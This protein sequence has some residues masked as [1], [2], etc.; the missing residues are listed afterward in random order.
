MT[1][2]EKGFR[3]EFARLSEKYNE[4]PALLD[5]K[6]GT[7]WTYADLA[8]LT[9]RA[10]AYLAANGA[11][12]GKT[13]VTLLPNS[14]DTLVL[15]LGALRVGANFAPLS[16]QARPREIRNWIELVDPVLCL[17]TPSTHDVVASAGAPPSLMPSGNMSQRISPQQ[18]TSSFPAMAVQ[19]LT[20]A[21]LTMFP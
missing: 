4:A 2:S 16:P 11:S 9:D 1:V 19:L 3:H 14:V 8:S 17:H 12:K 15:F 21:G 6:S 5:A 13:V 20:R 10:A 7:V 18:T